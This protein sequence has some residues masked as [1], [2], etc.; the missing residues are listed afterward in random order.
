MADW[1]SRRLHLWLLQ[2]L[3]SWCPRA[4]HP[5]SNQPRVACRLAPSALLLLSQWIALI[6]WNQSPAVRGNYIGRVTRCI[7]T[8]IGYARVLDAYHCISV[9]VAASFRM[10]CP[11]IVDRALEPSGPCMVAWCKECSVSWFI[12]LANPE[13]GDC[14]Q[15][16][17]RSYR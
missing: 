2:L 16:Y 7:L 11:S 9:R 6:L 10:D 4:N 5:L 14:H 12:R 3:F 13:A 17:P 1:V 8:V 15:A